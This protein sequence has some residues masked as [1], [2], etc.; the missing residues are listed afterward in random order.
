MTLELM[1]MSSKNKSRGFTLIELM[2]VV[3]IVGILAAIAYPS[4]RQSV[5]RSHRSEGQ[6]A[7]QQAAAQ[8]ERYYSRNSQYAPDVTTLG[9][10]GATEEGYYAV[11]ISAG[12]CGNTTRCYTLTATAQGTQTQDTGCT[13]L[14]LDSTGAK[15]PADC[16]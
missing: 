12:P 10:P 4:Y 7:L 11:A 15:T 3:A 5:V 6:V 2:I 13:T 1:N 9:V 8:M 14:T 16:W